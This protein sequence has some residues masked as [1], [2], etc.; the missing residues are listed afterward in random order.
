[1]SQ[2]PLNSSAAHGPASGGRRLV[3]MVGSILFV[4]G[5][6]LAVSG[7]L[8]AA[9]PTAAP[10]T[11][12][13][14]EDGGIVASTVVTGEI[15]I[16]PTAAPTVD[17]VVEPIIEPTSEPTSEPVSEPTA[18]P[19]VIPTPGPITTTE[20]ASTT[21]VAEPAAPTTTIYFAFVA[22]PLTAPDIS[23]SRPNSGNSWTVSWTDVG[24]TSY[25]IQ[26]SQSAD[27]SG[28]TTV[29]NGAAL[30]YPVTKPASPFNSYFYRVRGVGKQGQSGEWSD[31]IEV[32]GAYSD[33]FSSDNTNWDVRRTTFKEEVTSFYENPTDGW[34]ILRVEDSWDWGI[35]S[36]LAKA[37]EPPYVIEYRVQPANL[38]NLVSQGIVFGSDF[39][40]ASCAPI[41]TITGFDNIYKHTNC[42]NK[43]YATNTIWYGKLKLQFER[44]DQLVWCGSCGGSPMKRIGDVFTASDPIPNTDSNGFNTWRVEVRSSGIKIFA[45]GSEFYTYNDTRHINNPYFGVFA[46]T[47]EY[48]NSTARFDYFK[49]TPLDN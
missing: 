44:I 2:S 11:G 22:V 48:S 24:A 35:A 16:E 28:A 25:E 43:F 46:T 12:T 9:G 17:P 33:D 34:F 45:N 18:E 42:F 6:L 8:N 36:P 30:T 26:E 40:G 49:I 32:V 21:I 19:T 7:T 20:P 1:M 15:V 31:P 14:G 3:F 41:K 23:S 47:D 27:F 10:T 13:I 39:P 29:D 4:I 38:G 5:L 37:P